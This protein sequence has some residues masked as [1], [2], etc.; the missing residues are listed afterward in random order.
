MHIPESVADRLAAA[1]PDRIRAEGD[2][3]CSEII[4]RLTDVPGVAGVHVMAIGAESSIPAI[5]QD[6]G[7]AARSPAPA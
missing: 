7:L 2:K 6:A 3:L 5:L 1:S 4:A